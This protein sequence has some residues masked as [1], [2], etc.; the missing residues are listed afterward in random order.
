MVGLVGNVLMILAGLMFA[1]W[2]GD[3]VLQNDEMA[4]NKSK[5]MKA[6]LTHT[7][8]YSVVMW[9]TAQMML[10]FNVFGAQYWWAAILFGLIQFISHT[11]IDYVTSRMNAYYWVNEQRHNFFTNIGFGQ[12]LHFLVLIISLYAIFY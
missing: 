3:F 11:I 5:S 2:V 7:G 10:E 12:Y 1:H 8:V 6:L 9:F 4:T